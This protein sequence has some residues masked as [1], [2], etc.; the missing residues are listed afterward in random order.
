MSSVSLTSTDFG[1]I[2]QYL[3]E[4]LEST[5]NWTDFKWTGSNISIILNLICYQT[6][7][8]NYT[9]NLLANESF[10]SS[11]ILRNN[12]V[13]LAKTI[14]YTPKSATCSKLTLNM[15]VSLSEKESADY[16]TL[17]PGNVFGV[18][19]AKD[20]YNFNAIEQIT[21]PVNSSGTC[22]FMNL[23][24]Y[25]GVFVEMDFVVNT[26]IYNQRFLLSNLN[27]DTDTIRIS[28]SENSETFYAYTHAS[29]YANANFND[30]VF[31]IEEIDDGYH[32]I[33]F[34]DG[35]FG[36]KLQNGNKIHCT[37]IIT[38]GE[39]ANGF[40][41]ENNFTFTN[42]FYSNSGTKLKLTPT[43]LSDVISEGGANRENVSSIKFRAPKSYAAQ[44]RCVT[45]YDYESLVRDIYPAIDAIYVYGGEN[46]RNPQYGRVFV[47]IKP[48]S[49]IALSNSTK[50][51]IKSSLSN[52]RI[53]S[54]DISIVN[55]EVLFV[56]VISAVFYD[57][58]VTNLN[59]AKIESL[60]RTTLS[61]YAKSET[62]SR[63][64]GAIRYS[65]IVGA[66][67]ESDSSIVRNN[68][69]LR[70]RRDLKAVQNTL[71]TYELCFENPFSTC[72]DSA[73]VYSTGFRISENG[74]ANS[75]I[76][77]F[78]DNGAGKIQTFYFDSFRAKQIANSN[79]GDVNY[80]TGEITLGYANGITIIDTVIPNFIIQVRAICKN[81]D[82]IARNNIYLDLDI[83]NSTIVAT[84]N[85]K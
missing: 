1:E 24:L 23:T 66:I 80:E 22:Y 19:S 51:A 47:V 45:A 46:L 54:L 85:E 83:G 65:R 79:F 69:F 73:V 64:G 10:L 48:T 6:Q 74:I 30:R 7:L 27:I 60:V 34:G 11:A 50:N 20:S 9:A 59:S 84:S 55:P 36:R 63:F 33:I 49:G 21:A 56:E 37:Y 53:A 4:Y 68:T 26:T 40:T 12:V 14:G 75:T 5:S 28:V 81:Q 29:S 71:A 35:F 16:L 15:S 25:E 31:W 8:V 44:R 77:Y 32:E 58:R 17:N 76:Y 39:E 70:M 38:N 2:K 62:V 42:L 41:G 82:I 52:Y 57:I 67:D 3:T 13:S 72:R 18:S 78:E 43:I 61:N